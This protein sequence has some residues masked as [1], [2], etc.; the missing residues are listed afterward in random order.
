MSDSRQLG[1]P[2]L[3]D[4]ERETLQQIQHLLYPSGQERPGITPLPLTEDQRRLLAVLRVHCG[5]RSAIPLATICE[6]TKLGE[7]EVK[8]LMR[9]LVVD[10]KVRIGAARTQPYGYYLVTTAEEAREAAQV[11]E[12]EIIE[13]AKRVRVLRGKHFVAE[14]LGQ[15]RLEN[16]QEKAS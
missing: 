7:R 10:F 16:E 3:V 11:Y 12:S 6:R 4:Y 8:N 5:R 13:L 15:L 1:F 2:E 14:L 9:S